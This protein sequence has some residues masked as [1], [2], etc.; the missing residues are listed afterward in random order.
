MMIRILMLFIY[1]FIL[2]GIIRYQWTRFSISVRKYPI[3]INT[4]R[5]DIL[6][7][8][9]CTFLMRQFRRGVIWKITI[10]FT[11][12]WVPTNTPKKK[13]GGQIFNSE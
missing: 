1:G 6:P 12:F 2:F 10:Y 5:D 9:F 8:L 7:Y 3:R 4:G 11:D 13:I